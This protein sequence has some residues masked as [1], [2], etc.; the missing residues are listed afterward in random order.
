[1]SEK[2]PAV[3]KGK[4]R[5]R[6]YND[7]EEAYQA[8]LLQNR[9]YRQKD[10]EKFK[11]ARRIYNERYKQKKLAEQQRIQDEKDEQIRKLQE[12]QRIKDEQIAQLL[13][14]MKISQQV[15]E[16]V[17]ITSHSTSVSPTC[18]SASP[19][20][21]ITPIQSPIVMFPLQLPSVQNMPYN[22]CFSPIQPVS[23]SP[24]SSQP[25]PISYTLHPDSSIPTPNYS[26]LPPI[27]NNLVS[28]RK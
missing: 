12:E 4:G 17:T 1:M 25:R 24:R 26:F 2:A 27:S 15:S 8:K 9:S 22:S 21:I 3:S 23:I 10:P 6:K 11:E 20:P 19:E 5:P 16:P 14:S 18:S 7:A 28:L 13:A